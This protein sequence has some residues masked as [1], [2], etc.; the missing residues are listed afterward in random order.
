MYWKIHNKLVT[1]ITD[2]YAVS[3]K[4]SPMKLLGRR[5]LSKI[6]TDTKEEYGLGKET[7]VKTNTVLKRY[8]RRTK[9]KKMSMKSPLERIEPLIV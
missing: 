5:E 3:K 8:K 2:R 9:N 4:I 1:M 7:I 6:I